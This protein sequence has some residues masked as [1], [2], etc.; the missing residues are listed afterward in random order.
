MKTQFFLSIWWKKVKW[1]LFVFDRKTIFSSVEN[2][3]D[4]KIDFLKFPLYCFMNFVTISV[5]KSN[6]FEN[7]DFFDT[8][9]PRRSRPP[10][11]VEESPP[12]GEFFLKIWSNLKI[13]GSKSSFSCV[14]ND[15]DDRKISLN[16]I[17]NNFDQNLNK[18]R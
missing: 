9:L 8:I 18:K 2:K 17:R 16:F 7:I 11:V 4:K 12:W 15:F 1:K 3:S 14:L 13:L 6:N 5:F 10:E